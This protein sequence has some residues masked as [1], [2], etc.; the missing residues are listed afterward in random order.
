MSSHSIISA[1][2]ALRMGKMAGFRNLSVYDYT[3]I[4]LE[5]VKSIVRER[6]GDFEEFYRQVLVFREKRHFQMA[7]ASR[8]H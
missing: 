4:N 3:E 1:D 8:R 6:L 2:S 5:I 7:S